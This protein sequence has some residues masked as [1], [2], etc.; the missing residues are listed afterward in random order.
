MNF[1]FTVY[2]YIS[3]GAAILSLIPAIVGYARRHVPGSLAL[4]HL[5][6]AVFLWTFFAALEY[7]TVSVSGKILFSQL[8]YIGT[9]S[10]PIFFLFFALEY[11]R[12]DRWL[13]GLRAGFFFIIPL[14]TLVLAFT[15]AW[16]HL[17]WTSF[18]P[19]PVHENLII[20]GHGIGFWVGVTGYSYLLT[21]VGLVMLIRAAF[22]YRTVFRD[23]TVALVI[24]ALVP[25]VANIL[26]VSRTD[27]VPGLDITPISFVISGLALTWSIFRFRFLDLVPVARETLIETMEDG[28]IVL[29]GQRRVLDTN[30]AVRRLLQID[31]HTC[32]GHPIGQVFARFT[33]KEQGILNKE[34]G[35]VIVKLEDLHSTYVE[36]RSSTL[37]DRRN[38]P[39][40]FLLIV[41]DITERIHNETVSRSTQEQLQSQLFE[42]QTLQ[43]SLL[44]QVTHDA[45][46]GLYNRRYLDD[47]LDH[48]L[49]TYARAHLPVSVVMMD[50]DN[51]K[52]IND[53][54]G[55][56]A[57]DL[58]LQRISRLL[59]KKTRPS[60]LV[61]RYG[62]DE[63]VVIL[64]GMR[65]VIAV[66]RAEQ[67]RGQVERL[68]IKLEGNVVRTTVSAGVA[69]SPEAGDS[70]DA[71][72]RAAD[73]ALY[74][75]KSAGRNAV[76]FSGEK[77]RKR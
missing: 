14:V 46:T 62:G 25:L 73:A 32:L 43:S 44:K 17:I 77:D 45:L 54:F 23:Q 63:I 12:S 76:R 18:T 30:P 65:S 51:L 55:H 69:A 70:A 67:W 49:K 50:M 42:I 75:A 27:P 9:L 68:N 11:N 34:T 1:Q 74:A 38:H 15:N 35:R 20:Y 13:S 7:G 59:R 60:D 36:V 61:C 41:R 64:P 33:D 56:K 6:T 72:M 53:R 28:V 3:F 39:I 66:R 16:H 52:E 24:G 29:D 5:M 31:T 10:T 47:I 26:Y 71:I 57:G 48:H 8:E 2:V 4:A 40:G 21:L 22:L 37:H 58:A 19:S